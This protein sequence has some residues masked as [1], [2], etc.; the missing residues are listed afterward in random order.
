MKL[1]LTLANGAHRSAHGAVQSKS[2][3]FG[4]K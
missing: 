2:I 4:A 3:M 1:R